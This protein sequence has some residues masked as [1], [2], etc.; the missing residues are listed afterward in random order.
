MYDVRAIRSMYPHPMPA[1]CLHLTERGYCV[2][3]A[4]QCYVDRKEVPF[5]GAFPSPHTL[6]AVLRR[7][8]P[9]LNRFEARTLAGQITSANDTGEFDRAWDRAKEALS[10]HYEV[11][12]PES[13]S[14][15][16]PASEKT[17]E[18][19]SADLP[20]SSG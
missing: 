6:S 13:V 11:E 17:V 20:D 19:P 3:G 14:P 4:I 18:S 16:Q 10:L 5:G 7:A 15:A 9:R 2:G 12:L 1:R 8:N